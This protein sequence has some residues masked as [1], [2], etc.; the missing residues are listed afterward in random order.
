MSLLKFHISVEQIKQKIVYNYFLLMALDGAIMMFLSDSLAKFWHIITFS[1]L[2]ILFKTAK[3]DFSQIDKAILAFFMILVFSSLTNNYPLICLYTELK[4]LLWGYLFYYIGAHDRVKSIPFFEKGLFPFL[5]VCLIGLL[6]YVLMPGWYIAIK[7]DHAGRDVVSNTLISELSRLSAFWDYPYW[8]SYGCAF[9]YLYYFNYYHNTQ[10]KLKSLALFLFL[11]LIAIFTQQRA[12]LGFMAIVTLYYVILMIFRRRLKISNIKWLACLVFAVIIG[13]S[14]IL[15]FVSE[16]VLD[17]LLGKI[18]KLSDTKDFVSERADIFDSFYKK[19]IHI[20]GDGLGAYNHVAYSLGREAI[21]DHQYLKMLYETGIFGCVGF[22]IIFLS[23]FVKALSRVHYF[24]IELGIVFF[25]L[26]AMT[27]ANCMFVT[28][29]HSA[30]LWYC[31]GRILNHTKV[32]KLKNKCN[33]KLEYN[34]YE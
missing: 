13:V 16:D 30:I 27:G 14:L 10:L 3:R 5:V 18:L 2:V 23:A 19:P 24:R 15:N 22:S 25:F 28:Q 4:G 20:F 8:I 33:F 6:L 7:I 21:T 32:N 17:I 31:I 9:F 34:I 12:A 29:E 11:L 1:C 26:I